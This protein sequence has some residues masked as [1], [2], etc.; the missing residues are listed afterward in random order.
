MNLPKDFIDK[1]S[2]LL[3]DEMP[4]FLKALEQP[5]QKGITLNT[6][7]MNEKFF[8]E[9]FNEDIEK[10]PHTDNGYYVNS[11]KF[12]ENLFNHLGVI[13]SQEPSA[14][15]P[16]QLLDIKEGDIVLD[17]C[18]SPGG[19]SI[20]IL[21][22]LNGSGLLISNEIVYKRAKILQENICKMSFDN[23]IITCNSPEDFEDTNIKFDK[24]LVDAPCGGEGMIRKESFDISNY[25][26]STIETNSSRQLKILNSVKNLLKNNGTLVYSTCTYDIREN[27]GVIAKFLEENDDYEILNK[28]EFLDVCLKGIKVGNF[29]TEY[30]L[31]RYPHKHKGEGQFMIALKKKGE[32]IDENYT[33]K[34]TKLKNFTSLNKKEEDVIL[35]T[36]SKVIDKNEWEF[37]KKDIFIY[38][39]PKVK[40]NTENLNIVNAGV[41]VGELNKGILK[42]SHDFYHTY[43]R[44]FLN[45]IEL[46]ESDAKR[47]IHGEELDTEKPNG[48]YSI[49]YLSTTL[50]GG[51]VVDGKIKNYYPKNLRI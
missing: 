23:C 28:N 43:G 40:I 18:A 35:D 20:Q 47:Y 50:G 16:V 49:N 19:K 36:L 41:Y 14:M 5:S 51:K 29:N 13:Y 3:Q 38:S 26:P 21:E 42:L 46:S 37:V 48:I 8:L 7:K 2:N 1:M 17:V 4:D 15:Y 22:K 39:I 10:I 32:N 6:C 34:N 45:K 9:N 12:S 25:S 30:S 33:P 31:R 11:F 44:E 24:I 27:E